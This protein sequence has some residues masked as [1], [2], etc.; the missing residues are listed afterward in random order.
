MGGGQQQ[1]GMQQQ[2]QPL[3]QQDAMGLLQNL[4]NVAN[5]QQL[6]AAAQQ[7]QAGGGGLVQPQQG[8]GMQPLQQTG[9]MMGQQGGVVQ[10]QGGGGYAPRQQPAP[11]L[12]GMGP[13][14]WRR[15]RCVSSWAAARKVSSLSCVRMM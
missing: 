2:Q 6:L 4:G 1:M 5:L 12:G 14:A 10:P 8:Q 13:A 9:G 7:Q 3:Q 15:T 11:P